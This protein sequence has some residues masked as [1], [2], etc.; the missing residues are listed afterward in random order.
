ML[1]FASSLDRGCNR[2]TLGK[3]KCA[4]LVRRRERTKSYRGIGTECQKISIA[5]LQ[6]LENN[7]LEESRKTYCMLW[8]CLQGGWLVTNNSGTSGGAPSVAVVPRDVGIRYMSILLYRYV[9][10]TSVL[11]VYVYNDV[12]LG[13]LKLLRLFKCGSRDGLGK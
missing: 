10:L 5:G 1:I 9:S 4:S 12:I 3:S 7:K 2:K 13:S 11:Y 8:L 6:F